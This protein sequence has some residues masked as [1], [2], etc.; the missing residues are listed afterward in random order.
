MNKFWKKEIVK[1]DEDYV[2]N[3]KV[4]LVIKKYDNLAMNDAMMFLVCNISTTY[5]KIVY[6]LRRRDSI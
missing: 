6:Q 3:F 5:F 1:A 2:Y 4:P